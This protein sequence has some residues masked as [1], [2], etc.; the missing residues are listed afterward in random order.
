MGFSELIVIMLVALLVIGP[1]DFLGSVRVLVSWV[2]R[3]KE[4]FKTVAR[5]LENELGLNDIRSEVHNA[6]VLKEL[7]DLKG[8]IE[9]TN[10]IDK[11]PSKSTT[12]GDDDEASSTE[13]R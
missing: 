7:E 4:Q 1:K 3:I 9:Q 6:Q 10:C 8:D 2:I 11:A 13:T 12:S 5:D